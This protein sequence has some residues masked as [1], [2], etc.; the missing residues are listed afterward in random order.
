MKKAI[1]TTTML[2]LSSMLIAS[3]GDDNSTSQENK[4]NQANTAT[5]T[6]ANSAKKGKLNDIEFGKKASNPT[7]N[8]KTLIKNN[9]TNEIPHNK[10]ILGTI[11][12]MQNVD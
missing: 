12:D 2:I 5:T 10:T 8:E 7:S 1:L 4:V 3:C 6:L 11:K 9:K